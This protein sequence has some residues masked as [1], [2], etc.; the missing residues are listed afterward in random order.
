M[1]PVFHLKSVFIFLSMGIMIIIFK[2]RI[3]REQEKLIC[4]NL[5]LFV[6]DIVI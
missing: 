4:T 3:G 1:Y 6:F 5:I 2:L